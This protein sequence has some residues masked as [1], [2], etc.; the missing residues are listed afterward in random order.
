MSPRSAADRR[1]DYEAAGPA[2]RLGGKEA[3]PQQPAGTDSDS[4]K[5]HV[6]SVALEDYFHVTPLQTVVREDRWNRFEMRLE[7]STR[8]TLDL[9]DECGA[10]ATFFVLGWVA[11][12]APE[13]VREV[14]DRGHEVASKGYFHRPL[15]EAGPEAFREDAVRAREALERA[16][17]HRVLGYRLAEQWLRPS[18]GW[19]LE[20]LAESGYEYDSSVRLMLRTYAD[21]PWRQFPYRTVVAGR[22]FLEVPLSSIRVCGLHVPIAG[23]NYFRQFPDFLVRRAVAHWTRHYAAPY[24]M[25]FHTW[26]LDPDQPRINGVPLRQ[27]VRQYRNLRKMPE[28]L[29][30]YLESYRFT[31]IADYFELDRQPA[32]AR[33][34]R[35]GSAPPL[36]ERSPPS[37]VATVRALTPVTVV[38]PCYNEQQ[39]LPYLKNTLRSVVEQWAQQYRFQFVFV[40][41]CSADRT[42]ETLQATFGA[43]PG[44]TLM[45]HA[46]NRGVAAAI[47]T[48]IHAARTEIVCSMD[49]DCTYDPHELGRMIPLLTDGVDV[50]TASPYHPQGSVKNVP[51][52]RL[53]LSK[54]LSRAYR[55]VIR[56]QLH[57]YTSCFR[58]Y[59][60]ATAIGIPI[61]RGG[62]F[63][64]T[65]MLGRVDLAG[66]TI[67]EFP[68]TLEARM[69]GRSKMK[70]LRTIAGHLGL[71][72]QFVA[73]RLFRR[74]ERDR[75]GGGRDG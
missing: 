43:D 50:V 55:V 41:D 45:R 14:A 32:P 23:G 67:V 5:T 1:L 71:L 21:E 20:A 33:A 74:L 69:L 15:R 56:Q 53:F 10:R 63:G 64:I 37:P 57:T 38:V 72:C 44:C 39:S 16:V 34:G 12:A 24:V 75:R 46:E 61:E 65:E 52:W 70:I 22:S 6:L 30:H 31:S 9:L 3:A 26:E 51:R 48:G 59:R 7:A 13:L 19:V 49:C 18:D 58:V 68:A 17:G 73:L 28:L 29:R 42:W 11:D 35:D 62:F 66:G 60:R 8:R 54:S 27:Q 36:P 47:Q 40:D 25:Y 2:L 4:V